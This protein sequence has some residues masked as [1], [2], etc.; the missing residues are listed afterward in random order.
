MTKRTYPDKFAN[1]PP[2]NWM[3]SEPSYEEEEEFK[4]SGNE[5]QDLAIDR[6]RKLAAAKRGQTILKGNVGS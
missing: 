5:Y 1:G 6:A 4:K 2:D 3:E